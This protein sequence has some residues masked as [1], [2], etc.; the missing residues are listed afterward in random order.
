[1]GL[2]R[3]DLGKLPISRLLVRA[4]PSLTPVQ[5]PRIL[6]QQ[7]RG[8]RFNST[9]AAAPTSTPPEILE[10]AAPA[11][12]V[13]TQ[14]IALRDYQEECI[15]SVVRYV[16]EGHKRLG[17]SL[18]TGS[19]KTVRTPHYIERLFTDRL[20]LNERSYLPN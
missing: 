12:P 4:R 1:M 17:V 15:Q 3:Y 5:W 13:Q 16:D 20:F 14:G 19:G 7:R 2:L 18:A 8:W 9:L 10:P 6:P 11:A